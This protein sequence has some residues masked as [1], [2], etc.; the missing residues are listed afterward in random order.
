MEKKQCFC[1]ICSVGCPM[2]VWVENDKIVS[3]E[4]RVENGRSRGLCA[5]GAASKQYI[6]NDERIRYPM[7]RVGE[8]GSGKFERISW[9]EAY[10]FIAENLNR[11]K[12][13]YGA[14][15]VVFYA[16]YPKWYRPALLRLA[17]AFGTPNYCTESSTCFQASALA[18]KSIYGNGICF[19]DLVHTK[20]LLIWTSNLFHSN[21][22][23]GKMYRSLKE[24]GVRIIAVDPRNTV[25]VKEA[26]LHLKITPGTDGALAL[27]MAQV[28]IEE[29]LYDKEFVEKYIYGFEEYKEYVKSFTPEIAQ[30]ITGVDAELIREAARLYACN[31]PSAM[32]FSVSTIVHHING[33][34]NYRAVFCLIALTGNYDVTGG[35]RTMSGPVSPCN[36][37]GKVLRY[38]KEE[39]IGERDFPVWF[40]LP[41]QEAQCTKLADYILDQKPYPLKAVFAMGL[42]HRMWPQPDYLQKALGKLDFYV[43]T[44]LFWSDSS[45]M[46]DLVLPA[47][48]TFEREEVKTIRGGM[49]AFN[50]KAVEPVGEAKNDIEIIIELARR[51][52]LEDKVLTSGYESYMNY[53][54]EPSGLTIEELRN[55]P[56]GMK[57][58]RIIEPGEKSYET[59]P[60]HTPSGKIEF[61]SQI[62]EKYKDSRGYDGLPVYKDFREQNVIDRKKFPLILNTGSRKPQF[63]HARLYRIAWLDQLEISPMVEIHPEDGKRYG[64]ADGD[65]IKVISP[66]GEMEGTASWSIT[67]NPGIVY[68]YHG[69]KK[70]DANHL[71]DRTYLDPYTGFPGYKSYFCRIEKID[72]GG[73][74][75]CHII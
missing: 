58:K 35:N 32:Q 55:H 8:K 75:E 43:N 31:R 62:L 57:G 36:E 63:F 19:P 15:S 73:D 38:D 9:E 69:N 27:S 7:K 6:Y 18:W 51:M 17:N 61:R 4:G 59:K 64:I 1:G 24:R 34:Q 25:T 37:F 53:I 5:K 22:P 16:G 12:K 33:F 30:E 29:E 44:E 40:D 3:V 11:I 65:R 47:C 48:T 49:F 46:A 2:D 72:S 67:G 50:Q 23:M 52:Q 60:F 74:G 39:A 20:T 21:T 54:L 56:G 70:G 42:N 14:R 68:I 26:D 13:E 66:A 45:R 41:C 71:I 10:D 28:I